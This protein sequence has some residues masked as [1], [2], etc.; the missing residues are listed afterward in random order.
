MI[1]G[2]RPAVLLEPTAAAAGPKTEE[3][4]AVAYKE[5]ALAVAVAVACKEDALAVAVAHKEEALAVAY[6][7]HACM[8]GRGSQGFPGGSHGLA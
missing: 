2:G 1:G 7:S 3:A 5:E 6:K 8:R 4:M